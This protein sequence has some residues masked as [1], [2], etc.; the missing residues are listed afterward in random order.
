MVSLHCRRALTRTE[1][2]CTDRTDP[3]RTA[4]VI[5]DACVPSRIRPVAL[6]QKDDP[7]GPPLRIKFQASCRQFI[8]VRA[9]LAVSPAGLPRI[10]EDGNRRFLFSCSH[11]PSLALR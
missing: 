4:F 10:G 3:N 11:T 9:P 6:S 8:G 7:T 5:P 2:S 1:F